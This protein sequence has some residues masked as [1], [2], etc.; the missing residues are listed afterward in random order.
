MV[1]PDRSVPT[2][3][4][5]LSI[6]GAGILTGLAG[7]TG[8]GETPPEDDTGENG[9]SSNDAGTDDADEDGTEGSDH[10]SDDGDTNSSE[11]SLE[12]PVEYPADATCPVCNMVPAEYPA[13]N[14]QLAHENGDRVFFDSSGCLAAYVAYPD[15]F[16][17]PDSALDMAWVTGFETGVLLDASEAH[18]VRVNDP[19]H[20]DDVM[21]MN[22]TPFADRADA[23]AFVDEYETYDEDD[24]IGFDEFDRELA[25]LYR[26]R[27][28]DDENGGMNHDE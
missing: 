2:R 7:C 24:I 22:P 11:T 18:F 27:F 19:D 20:V 15:R 13:W 25:E 16:D 4:T 12:D 21:R 23:K 28:L 26:A 9:A 3:R 5:V 8:N 6:A 14:A 1:E 10:E 17:A